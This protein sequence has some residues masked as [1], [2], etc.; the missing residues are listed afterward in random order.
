VDSGPNGEHGY[1]TQDVPGLVDTIRIVPWGGFAFPAEPDLLTVAYRV[2]SEP[3]WHFLTIPARAQ[4]RDGLTII[5]SRIL[6]PGVL[7]ND[8]RSSGVL[9]SCALSAPGKD[10]EWR[11]SPTSVKAMAPAR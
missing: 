3:A 6:V 2:A 11:W 9:R 8:M 5:V 10:S 1:P 4:E 7:T